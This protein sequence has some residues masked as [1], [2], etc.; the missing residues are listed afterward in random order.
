MST[1]DDGR[2]VPRLSFGTDPNYVRFGEYPQTEADDSIKSTLSE[3]SA[4]ADGYYHY[5]GERYEKKSNRFFKVE[6]IIWRVKNASNSGYILLMSDK[7]LDCY[8]F[9]PTVL[10]NQS[11]NVSFS[12]SYLKT[13]MNDT[14]YNKAFPYNQ[15]MISDAEAGAKVFTLDIFNVYWA[16]NGFTQEG[17]LDELSLT[18]KVTDYA[19]C[20]GVK[21]S[22]EVG[23][24]GNGMYWLRET[25]GKQAYVVDEDGSVLL[26]NA[27][28][29]YTGVL[30]FIRISIE[31]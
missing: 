6:P 29:T 14:L 5:E 10:M 25:E 17:V 15:N 23:Y 2:I 9:D 28:N 31:D 1:Y 21:K 12:T 18:A 24:E 19:N 3:L 8:T 30:P 26:M 16:E 22:K 4:S 13:Y 27:A 11:K 20:A 7:I